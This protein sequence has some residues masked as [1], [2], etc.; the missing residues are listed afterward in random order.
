MLLAGARR[1][2]TSCDVTFRLPLNEGREL[3]VDI[4][5]EP[6]AD[7]SLMI[8]GL[9]VGI[10]GLDI[11][12]R[13]ENPSATGAEKYGRNY[14]TSYNATYDEILRGVRNAARDYLPESQVQ[15]G[16]VDV[17]QVAKEQAEKK[18]LRIPWI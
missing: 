11:M 12:Y 7:D 3:Y 15:T 17:L 6:D 10:Q 9:A 4:H 1:D 2:S 18:H 5:M 13:V 14:Y 8:R 16:P